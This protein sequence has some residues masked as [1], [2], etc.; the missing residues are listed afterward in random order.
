LRVLV[1]AH[2]R[3]K[4]G[5]KKMPWKAVIDEHCDDEVGITVRMLM[6][7]RTITTNT[8]RAEAFCEI[9]GADRATFY[10]RMKHIKPYRPTKKVRRVILKHKEPPRQDRPPD[11]VVFQG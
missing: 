3:K 10:R 9:T 1:K 5:M 8:A 7:N 6:D 2:A 11:G 4:A